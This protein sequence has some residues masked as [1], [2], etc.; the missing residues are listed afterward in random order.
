MN[1]DV[2]LRLE[3][4]DARDRW[5]CGPRLQICV[6]V[7]KVGVRH[8]TFG[9]TRHLV[10]RPSYIRGQRREWKWSRRKSWTC[11]A[12]LTLV[13]VALVAAVAGEELLAGVGVAG[14]RLGRLRLRC[15]G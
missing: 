13:T 14:G 11:D 10:G 5:R 6:D 12:S 2:P 4:R 7:S 3:Q 9:V 8:E 15:G 1:L